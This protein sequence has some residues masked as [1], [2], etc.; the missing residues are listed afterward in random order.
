MPLSVSIISHPK[1]G[2]TG[3]HVRDRARQALSQSLAFSQRFPASAGTLMQTNAPPLGMNDPPDLM[4]SA[5]T[6]SMRSCP[7]AGSAAPPAPDPDGLQD[8]SAT[9]ISS[10]QPIPRMC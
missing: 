3:A 2:F 8:A 9:T 4:Q 5:W 1:S 6:S 10:P 7:T